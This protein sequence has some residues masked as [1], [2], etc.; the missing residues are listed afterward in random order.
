MSSRKAYL[1]VNPL[2]VQQVLHVDKIWWV[3]TPKNLLIND[4][5]I[6]YYELDKD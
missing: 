3:Q 2:K 6:Y 4:L 1:I 5:F